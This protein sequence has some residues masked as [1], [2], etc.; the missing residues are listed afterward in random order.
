[1]WEPTAAVAAAT[2]A[3]DCLEGAEP[4]VRPLSTTGR[5]GEAQ[6]RGN[7]C[8]CAG[9]CSLPLGHRARGRACTDQAADDVTP[10]LLS[11]AGYAKRLT[12]AKNEDRCARLGAGPRWGTPELRLAAGYEPMPVVRQG[13]APDGNRKCGIQPAH[14]S[15]STDVQ[16]S[17]LLP[18]IAISLPGNSRDERDG[19]NASYPLKA[20]IRAA[21]CHHG[22]V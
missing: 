19:N 14:Q 7:H 17:R 12:P 21:R 6:H 22:C 2:S 5:E 20:D 1:M 4:D 8:D 18:C 9:N 10:P 3:R 11:A 16:R 15:R 13:P